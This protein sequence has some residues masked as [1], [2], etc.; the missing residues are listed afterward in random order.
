MRSVVLL[1]GLLVVGLIFGGIILLVVVLATR[2]RRQP[3]PRLPT[4]DVKETNASPEERQAILKR[5]ADGEISKQ[6][7]ED[8]IS[9]LGTPVPSGMPTPPPRS[10]MGTGC[11]IALVIGLLTVPVI[12]LLLVVSMFFVRVS[13]RTEYTM[14]HMDDGTTHTEEMAR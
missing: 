4:G 6:E 2:G 12:I 8:Q 3:A 1:A 10:G 7:A 11:L 14:E 9:Q 13:H 5:L